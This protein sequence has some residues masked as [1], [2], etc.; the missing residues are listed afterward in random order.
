MGGSYGQERRRDQSGYI[1]DDPGHERP[2]LKALWEN[3]E[4]F[5]DV[6]N[7][8]R[9]EHFPNPFH[10]EI[11]NAMQTLYRQMLREGGVDV[12]KWGAERHNIVRR[13]LDGSGRATRF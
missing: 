8:L 13:F 3:P 12:E 2:L 10:G 5:A 9:A 1:T 4:G 7:S 6:P 11:F